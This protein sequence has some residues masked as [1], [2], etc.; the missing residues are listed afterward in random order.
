MVKPLSV[1]VLSPALNVGAVTVPANV[2]A[3]ANLTFTLPV[4][5]TNTPTL[6]SLVSASVVIAP[7]IVKLS[8]SFLDVSPELPANFIGDSNCVLTSVS[9]VVPASSLTFSASN[10]KS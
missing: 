2:G 1:N 5:S 6:V 3:L 9:P 10:F 8:P 7:L 4:A